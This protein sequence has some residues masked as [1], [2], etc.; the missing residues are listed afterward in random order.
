MSF[1]T[2]LLIFGIF[3]WGMWRVLRREVTKGGRGG[4]Q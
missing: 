3:V 4:V 1:M 2:L